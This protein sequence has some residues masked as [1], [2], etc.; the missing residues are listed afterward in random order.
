MRTFLNDVRRNASIL[1]AT[2][3]G[4]EERRHGRAGD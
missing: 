1:G 3:R 2:A 4:I